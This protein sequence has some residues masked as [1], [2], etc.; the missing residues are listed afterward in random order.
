[1]DLV[2]AFVLAIVQGLSEFLPISSSGHLVLIPHFL[3][4]PDQGIAFDVR[5]APGH[6]RRLVTLFPGLAGDVA[7]CLG[8]VHRAAHADSREPLAWQLLV[9]TIPVSL[10]GLL[11]NHYIEDHLRQP[12]F[13][14]GTL[15]FF[16]LLMYAA[17]R[18]GTRRAHR[19]RRELA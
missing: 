18:W 4:W 19:I 15:T 7:A 3:G 9:A 6:A 10:V 5:A 14:A 16:G 8:R 17:D 11:F 13:I 2:Q 12:L 1:M